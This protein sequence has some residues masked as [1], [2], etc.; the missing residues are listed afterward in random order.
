MNV[1]KGDAS[2]GL[3]SIL[4]RDD[5]AAR[6]FFEEERDTH[7]TYRELS[8]IHY[9]LL[10][11]LPMIK[12]SSVKFLVDSQS[13][14]RIVDTGSMKEHLYWFATEIFHNCLENNIGAKSGLDFQVAKY[15]G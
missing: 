2:T 5:I 7:S 3:D 4:N 6:V 14:A 10:S 12:N 9:S 11:F 8:N 13:A 15:S 1:I